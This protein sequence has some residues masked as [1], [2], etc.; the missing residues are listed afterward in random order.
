MAQFEDGLPYVAWGSRYL[1]LESPN[2]KATDVKVFQT[3]FNQFIE[4]S[5]PPEGP[6]GSPIVVDGIFGRKTE[7]AVREWQEYFGLS[8]D[9]VIGPVTGATLGQYAPA[10]GGPRFG[11]RPLSDGQSGGDVTVLQNRLNCYRYAVDIGQPA[12]GQFGSMTADAVRHFQADMDCGPDAGVPVD[13]VV[14]FETF[15]AL[16]AYTYVGGRGLFR[17]RN[18]IDTLWLQHFLRCYSSYRGPLDG[19]F[20]EGTERA[21][22][23]FQ[24]SVHITVDGVVGQATMFNMGKTFNQPAPNWP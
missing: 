15:D 22:R 3:L 10:Y 4:H 7:W 20:G 16:W 19:Y 23:D 8:V 6:L 17:G 5:N 11:S 18:G 14:R 24:A 13:G 2:L 12:D 21:V 1:R 9:G